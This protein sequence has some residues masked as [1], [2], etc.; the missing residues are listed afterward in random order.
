MCAKMGVVYFAINYVLSECENG[1]MC[2]TNGNT[3]TI[4]GENIKNKYSRVVGFLTSVHNWHQTR[5]EEDF[6]NRQFYKGNEI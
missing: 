6:P 1:H 4:C 5:R 3:C 2:V